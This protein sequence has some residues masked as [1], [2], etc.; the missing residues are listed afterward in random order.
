MNY[1]ISHYNWI[2][3]DKQILITND[4]GRYCFLTENE[5]SDF[6]DRKISQDI[7]IF[8]ILKEKGFIYYDKDSYI[9]E[10]K[11]DMAGM[12]RCLTTGTNLV[13]LALTNLC[14][15]RC[16]YCQA[17]KA[18]TEQMPLE[19]CRKAVDIAVQ[20]PVSHMT[21]EFQGGEPTLNP[22]ALRF[23]VPYA[24]QIFAEHGKHVE[25]A[26][27]SNM[28]NPD[29]ELLRWLI[30]QDVSISTSLDG[31]RA[32]HEYNRPLASNK[33]SYDAWRSGIKLYKKLCLESG[34]KPSINAIQTTTRKSLKFYKEIIDEYVFN[35]M[36]HIYL[37][38][39][40]PLG[41]A[42][43]HWDIIGYSPEEYLEFYCRALDEMIKRC[44]HGN[45][46]TEASASI[47]LRRILNGEPSAHTEFRS[48]CGAAVGQIAVNYDGNIYTC[49]EGRML[50]NMGDDI[51]KLGTIENSYIELL[52]SPA[53]HAVCTAS[54]IEALP[55]C[56]GCV[57]S[58]Y[59]S[60]CPVINYAFE[61][62]LI[63][64]DEHNYKCVIAKGILEYLFKIIKRNDPAEIDI[65]KLWTAQN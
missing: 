7:N 19:V 64:R 6:I 4:I 44:I 23:T 63:S 59:C 17:G 37:R 28:T 60:V 38:P 8:N 1:F 61:H 48:P 51:F 58:P 39:L 14:N 45:Y 40:T 10:F 34:K 26:I 11:Y 3:H 36:N 2:Y 16:V 24:R 35:G 5:F 53:A 56:C 46:I 50:A 31:N 49:D 32:I 55:L 33:S 20:S 54:C 25:F 12:K 22:E 30:E 65:L 42:L 15:Q 41:C 47:Y 62:D 52:K 9:S 18:H 29:P 13:I 43:E 27:V 57:Y 21:I